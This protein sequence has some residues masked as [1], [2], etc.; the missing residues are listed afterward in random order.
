MYDT[1]PARILKV[2]GVMI[3]L[4]VGGCLIMIAIVG[5]IRLWHV[6]CG[7]SKF[8]YGLLTRPFRQRRHRAG[9]ATC[10]ARPLSRRDRSYVAVKRSLI[11]AAVLLIAASCL[12]SASVNSASN[13]SESPV[14]QIEPAPT[15]VI[16]PT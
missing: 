12:L 11:A 8:I 14:A 1:A 2:I 5:I 13:P 9:L 7:L 10:E 6:L 4:A 15:T 3:R 16:F